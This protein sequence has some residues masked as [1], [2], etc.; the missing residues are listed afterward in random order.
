[1]KTICI[2]GSGQGGTMLANWCSSQNKIVGFIDNNPKQWGK[3]IDNIEILSLTNAIEKKP[4]EIWI[5][6]LN[7][8]A[9]RDIYEQIIKSSYLGGIVCIS[10][11]QKRM[12]YRLATLRLYAEEIKKRNIEGEIAELGVY[13]GELAAEMNFLFPDRRLYLFDTF[14][15]FDRRNIENE[16]KHAYS[17]AQIGDFS[18]T[19]V[20]TVLERMPY[21]EQVIIK[22]GFFP[23]SVDEELPMFAMVSI[24]PDLYEPTYAGLK[25]F[26]PRLSSGGCIII[27]DY[28]SKQF[29]GVHEAV[30]KFCIENSLYVVPIPDLHGSALIVKP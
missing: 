19:S 17:K 16:S 12:D 9:E 24:D 26:Y 6:V 28:N 13:K 20:N 30:Y 25:V 23:E 1:M 4:D 29:A 14:E 8:E 22:K 18:D 15:G 7:K 10:Y 5:A 2:F 3:R 21:R 27:H 11:I